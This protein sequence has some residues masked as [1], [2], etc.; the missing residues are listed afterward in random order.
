MTAPVF[1]VDRVPGAPGTVT[2]DGPEGRHAVSVRRLRV[3]EEIVLT[4]GAGTGAYGTVAAVEGKDRLDV[5]VTE[6]RTEPVP[7]PRITVVQALPK[8]DRGE[9]A[10]E[11]MTE[12]GVDAIVPWAAS[13]CIT[14]WKGDRGLKALGKWRATA[15]EAGKQ[16]RRLRFP[17]VADAAS[18]KRVAQLLAAADFAAVLHEEGAEPLAAAELPATGDIVLVVGPE[19]GVSPEELAAFAEAG[20]KPYRLGRSVLRTSTAGTAATALLLGRTGRW[21]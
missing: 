9:L 12:T 5:A 8:G 18:T 7:A 13:R 17:D 6:V 3:G 20:A 10:V 2:L 21:S 16:S 4:D 1:L 14:Q 11:T 15:R 19:G